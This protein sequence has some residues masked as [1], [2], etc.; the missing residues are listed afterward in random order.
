[1]ANRNQ[2]NQ[3]YIEVLN[4]LEILGLKGGG[5]DDGLL[6]G[7]LRCAVLITKDVNTSQI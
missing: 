1:M 4:N 7:V 3:S 2:T 5:G 6:C